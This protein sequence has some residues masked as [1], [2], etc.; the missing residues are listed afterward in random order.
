MPSPSLE[1]ERE[2]LSISSHCDWVSENWS[3]RFSFSI[4]SR[5]GGC[6]DSKFRALRCITSIF[7]R[8]I[9]H[10]D[11]SEEHKAPQAIET[12]AI[13]LSAVSIAIS[14]GDILTIEQFLYHSC[15]NPNIFRA[16]G[17]ELLFKALEYQQYSILAMLLRDHRIDVNSEDSRGRTALHFAVIYDDL[18]AI[19][20][21]MTHKM[22]KLNHLDS[23]GDTA[24][25][26]AA[27]TFDGGLSCRKILDSLISSPDVMVNQRDSRGRS[28]IWHAAN[29]GNCDLVQKL[30]LLPEIKL[31]AADNDGIAPQERARQQGNLTIM[32]LLENIR[33]QRDTQ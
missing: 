25:L 4:A 1:T 14:T 26:L 27:R 32:D 24:L 15:T 19:H 22:I 8:Q 11:S 30:S 21:L 23:A 9:E 31:D 33:S 7:I 12:E 17:R 10:V 3:H 29:T 16:L 20:L 18:T 6:S 2:G 28:I 5:F 13:D